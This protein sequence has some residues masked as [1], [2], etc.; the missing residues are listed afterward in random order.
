[1]NTSQEGID[2]IKGFE[3]FRS[4]SYQDSVGIWTIGYG[5]TRYATGKHVGPNEQIAETV[6]DILLTQ[7]IHQNDQV[8]NQVIKVTIPQNQ[9]DALSSLMYNIGDGA[10]STS[11]LLRVLNSG[12]HTAASA[13]FLDWDRI[14]L[15]GEKIVAPGL[16]N[17]RKKEQALFLR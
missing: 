13:H 17:R 7:K 15:H 6:A 10:F 11:T 1:M 12:D 3:E 2:L 8:M 9:W 16:L 14:T 5:S 4:H